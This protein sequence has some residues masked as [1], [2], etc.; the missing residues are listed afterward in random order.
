MTQ[1]PAACGRNRTW[2]E[3]EMSRRMSKMKAI[4]GRSAAMIGK[5]L[6]RSHSEIGSPASRRFHQLG[7]DVLI[8]NLVRGHD[9][10]LEVAAGFGK[11]GDHLPVFAV[12]QLRRQRLR[13]TGQ[14]LQTGKGKR[15]RRE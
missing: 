7:H 1:Q 6:L 4:F 2:I 12:T 8:T 11:I 13:R 3:T 14:R 10:V 9:V 5:V 15:E